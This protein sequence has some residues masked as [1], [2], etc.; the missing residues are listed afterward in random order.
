MSLGVRGGGYKRTARAEPLSR[1]LAAEAATSKEQNLVTLKIA[2]ITP[3][4]T[5]DMVLVPSL[6]QE[7]R[8]AIHWTTRQNVSRTF[9]CSTVVALM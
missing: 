3:D 7:T 6:R 4:G 2:K 1:L 5:A 8:R 9:L